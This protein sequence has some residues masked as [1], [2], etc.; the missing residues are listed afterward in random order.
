MNFGTIKPPKHVAKVSY[1]FIYGCFHS[2]KSSFVEQALR[3]SV[4]PPIYI[5]VCIFRTG[6]PSVVIPVID[7]VLHSITGGLTNM[8]KQ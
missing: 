4:S 2:A 5:P 7:L 6:D 3:K 1:H 8:D